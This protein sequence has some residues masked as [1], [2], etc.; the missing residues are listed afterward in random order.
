MAFWAWTIGIYVSF[1]P[2]ITNNQ[3]DGQHSAAVS[4][5]ARLFFA[6]VILS[7]ALL[8]EKFSIQW[9]A[10]KFHEKSYAERIADQKSAVNVLVTL[11]AHSSDIPGRGD[12]LHDPSTSARKGSVDATRIFKAALKG[13]RNTVKTTTTALGNVAS[14]IA[15]R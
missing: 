9:I 4:L 5:L 13:V 1:N 15:G 10:G 11:Y 6:F 8:F 3:Q 2:L 7:S 14:E 12:T